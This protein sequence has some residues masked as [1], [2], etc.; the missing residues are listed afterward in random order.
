[1]ALNVVTHNKFVKFAQK[2]GLGRANCARPLQKRYVS[3]RV[4]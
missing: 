3:R 2:A 4:W 1:M